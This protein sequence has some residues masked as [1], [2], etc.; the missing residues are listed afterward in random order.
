MANSN[1]ISVIVAFDA[2]KNRLDIDKDCNR[3]QLERAIKGKLPE[4]F[5]LNHIYIIPKIMMSVYTYSGWVCGRERPLL[6][7]GSI[8]KFSLDILKF[9]DEAYT[10]GV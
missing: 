1:C 7:I 3:D 8:K 9:A 4:K 5:V 2:E 6:Q 10:L